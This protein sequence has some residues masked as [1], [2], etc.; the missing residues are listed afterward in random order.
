MSLR[1]RS[2][3]VVAWLIS[4]WTVAA[5]GQTPRVTTPEPAWPEKVFSGRDFGFRVDGYEGTVP[6]GK[7]VVRVKDRWVEVEPKSE[8]QVRK[9]LR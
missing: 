8:P 5:I 3:L 6:V 4:L 9:T 7:F 1:I 2:V